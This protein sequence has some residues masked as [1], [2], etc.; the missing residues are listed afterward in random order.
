[1]T[2]AYV[3]VMPSRLADGAAGE[4]E[5]RIFEN[6][7]VFDTRIAWDLAVVNIV[8]ISRV[9]IVAVLISFTR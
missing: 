8:F 1:M 5:N 9:P 4:S 2:G 6:I 7:A 3:T